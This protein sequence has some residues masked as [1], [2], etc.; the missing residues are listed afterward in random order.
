M[1]KELLNR[2]KQV[3]KEKQISAQ[4]LADELNVQRVTYYKY[5]KGTLTLNINQLI[6]IMKVLDLTWAD[7]GNY[8]KPVSFY[9]IQAPMQLVERYSIALA[10]V[11]MTQ[12]ADQLLEMDKSH[13]NEAKK[14]ISDR[15][16]ELAIILAEGLHNLEQKYSSL[17]ENSVNNHS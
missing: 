16:F 14:K 3:R 12:M 9:N 1:S 15:I 2:I 4:Y 11:I 5:E 8:Q 10:P 6:M 7:L 13:W 17:P